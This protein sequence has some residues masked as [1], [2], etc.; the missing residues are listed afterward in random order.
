MK[1]KIPSN[2]QGNG[3]ERLIRTYN[4]KITRKVEIVNANLLKTQQTLKEKDGSYT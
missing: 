4:P 2:D 3:K 1:V